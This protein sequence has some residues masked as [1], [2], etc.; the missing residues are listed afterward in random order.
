MNLTSLKLSQIEETIFKIILFHKEIIVKRIVELSNHDKKVIYENLEKLQRKGLITS[1]IKDRKRHYSFSGIEQIK[2]L[3]QEDERIFTERK[4]QSQQLISDIK[5]LQ[6]KVNEISQ[7]EL[8]LG[9]QSIRQFFQSIINKKESYS[10]I[11]VPIESEQI[12]GNVFW[13]NF[14]LKQK[15]QKIKAR[16]IFNPSLHSWKPNNTNLKIKYLDVEPLTET[17][18]FEDKIAIIIWTQDP[19][20]TIIRS[21]TVAK[22]YA[23]FFELLWKQ[24]KK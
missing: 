10:V 15:E 21:K 19:S 17:I 6:P 12:L 24:A 22:S 5:Q 4:K 11:G 16:L 2:S 20:A 13:E 3:I 8:L 1:V 7:T 23:S 14:H 18:I 9:K